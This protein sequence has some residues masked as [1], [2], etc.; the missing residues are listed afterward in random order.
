ML[1]IDLVCREGEGER[2]REGKRE[3]ERQANGVWE[4][5]TV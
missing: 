2:G 4:K 1:R 5:H 3:R